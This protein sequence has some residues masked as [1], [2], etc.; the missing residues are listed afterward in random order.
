MSTSAEFGIR[1]EKGHWRPPYPVRLA[2]RRKY[3]PQWL[4]PDNKKFLFGHQ[5]Y[6]NVFRSCA[7]GAD[8]RLW[9]RGLQGR[10]V[11]DEGKSLR[12]SR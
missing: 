3:H 10:A 7:H 1:D 2:D 5:T 6:D 4:S 11:P 8:P 9:P 12:L